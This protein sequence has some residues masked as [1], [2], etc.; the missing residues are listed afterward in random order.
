M[1][2]IAYS[3][4]LT[5]CVAMTSPKVLCPKAR[6]YVWRDESYGE[7]AEIHETFEDVEWFQHEK[8]DPLSCLVLT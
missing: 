1:S 2:R 3:I 6:I 4:V 8:N 5:L 7:I